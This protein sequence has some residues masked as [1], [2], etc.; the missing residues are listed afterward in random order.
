M[1]RIFSMFRFLK[2]MDKVLGEI[3]EMD[4][5]DGDNPNRP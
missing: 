4:E 5:V 2:T 3:Q 1:P